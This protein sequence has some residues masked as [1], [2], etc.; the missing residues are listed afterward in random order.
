MFAFRKR[1]KSIS[2]SSQIINKLGLAFAMQP[3]AFLWFCS[4]LTW[5]LLASANQS[6]NPT[7]KEVFNLALEIRCDCL[8]S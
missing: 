3:T 6:A 1:N 2:C 4:Y 8:C 7:A 5:V